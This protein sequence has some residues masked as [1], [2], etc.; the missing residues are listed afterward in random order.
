MYLYLNIQFQMIS[1]N[2]ANSSITNTPSI[3]PFLLITEKY[4]F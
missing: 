1:L 4:D 2:S 3:I